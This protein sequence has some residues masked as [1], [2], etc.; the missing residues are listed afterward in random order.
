MRLKLKM[1]SII[2]AILCISGCEK[3][4]YHT[5]IW[6]IGY[7][8]PDW[9]LDRNVGEQID[10]MFSV[11]IRELYVKN[12]SHPFGHII[13]PGI[14]IIENEHGYVECSCSATGYAGATYQTKHNRIHLYVTN[15]YYSVLWALSH[16]LHHFFSYTIHG[17]LDGNHV[18]LF[19]DVSRARD[20]AEYEWSQKYP[21]PR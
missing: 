13:K 18:D 21:Y 3:Y 6:D 7:E 15:Q 9:V 20:I 4:K 10:F 1:F 2:M 17:D 19:P 8:C 12:G 5:P 11:Y 16:E 14:R